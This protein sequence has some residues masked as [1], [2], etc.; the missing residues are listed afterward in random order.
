MAHR[1]LGDVRRGAPPGCSRPCSHAGQLPIHVSKRSE[2]GTADKAAFRPQ[3]AAGMPCRASLLIEDRMSYDDSC[4]ERRT[5]PHGSERAVKGHRLACSALYDLQQPGVTSNWSSAQ[6]D[7]PIP[8]VQVVQG[9]RC[10]GRW[11][12][13]LTCFN[14]NNSLPVVAAPVR[15]FR[16]TQTQS[17]AQSS[18][19][20][21]R[22]SDTTGPTLLPGS[23]NDLLIR[24][25]CC[26]SS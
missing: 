8:V 12:D 11:P 15:C 25:R 1:Y 23:V 5:W 19:T 6:V 4:V 20:P 3:L 14:Q 22:S 26:R 2:T 9:A 18:C 13:W 7:T 17:N 24:L 21:A 10:H 16:S